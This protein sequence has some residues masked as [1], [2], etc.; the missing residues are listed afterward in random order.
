MQ[1]S[2][3]GFAEKKK[4]GGQWLKIT[5]VHKHYAKAAWSAPLLFA[6][7]KTR[8]LTMILHGHTLGTYTGILPHNT[9]L[10]TRVTMTVADIKML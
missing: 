4:S 1:G 7:N 6:T 10:V 3:Q 9:S 2:W 8:G 5:I